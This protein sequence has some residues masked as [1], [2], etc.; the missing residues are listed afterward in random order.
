[1]WK[2]FQ[3]KASD[4]IVVGANDKG[5]QST[6]YGGQGACGVSDAVDKLGGRVRGEMSRRRFFAMSSGALASV[7]AS[8]LFA[9]AAATG[10]GDGFVLRAPLGNPFYGWPE[11]LLSYAVRGEVSAASHT[12][13]CVETGAAVPFQV[14]QHGIAGTAAGGDSILFLSELPV[15]ATRS[16][17]LA[18]GASR[19]VFAHAVTV[20][21]DG[22][23]FTID[24]GAMQVRIPASQVVAGEAPGPI[25]EVARGGGWKGSSRL[26]IPGHRVTRIETEQLETGPLRSAYRITYSIDD[27]A[28]YVATVECCAGMDFVRLHEA[29]EAMPEG[30]MG[31]FHFAWT[32][33][34]FAYRQGPNHPYNFPKQ[35]LAD[36]KQYAWEKMAPTHMDG[37]FGVNPGIGATGKIPYA[38]RLYDPWSD[39]VA[40]SFNNFWGDDSADA[41]MLFIDH[42][43]Q[44]RDHEYA[45]WH[46]SPRLAVEYWYIDR[47]LHFVYKIG[48]GSRSSCI[49]F[50]DHA[51]DVEAMQALTEVARGIVS[52]GLS[53]KTNMFPT[54]HAL[55]TQS[56]HGTLNLD[57]VKDWVLAYPAEKKLPGPVFRESAYRS[58]NA[59]Y[60]AITHNEYVSQ[61]VLSGTRQN[62]G[63]GATG[64]RQILESWVPGYN[65]FRA[66]MS[67]SQRERVEAAMLLMAYVHAGEDYM[68]MKPM[69]AGHPNFLSDVKSTPCGM[70]FL[71]PEHPAADEWADEYEAF[72]RL[73]TRYHTR[74]A[75]AEWRSRGGR[76]T[77]NLGT[78]VWAFLRP[79]SRAAFL[80]KCRD[81]QE[82][83]CGP[84]LAEL[85]DWLVN[86]LSAPFAGESAAWMKRITEESASNESSERHYWGIVKPTGGPRRVHPPIGAHSERRKTPRTM[87]Y[88]GQ[89]LSH[90]SPLTAE[91]VMWAARPTDQD[92]EAT[93]DMGDPYGAMYPAE[94]NLGTNP[95]LKTAK[96]TGYG[97]TLRAAVDTP[98][99]LSIHL[100]QIDDGPNYRWG[101][102]GEGACGVIYF[103]A[104]G[105]GFSH[106][107]FE[108]AGDRIDQDTDF[109]TN[110]GVWKNGV[111]RS[112]GQNV[113]TRPLYDLSVAQYASLVPRQGPEAYSWPEYVGR[114]ILLAGDD[115]FLIY[116]Q[117]FNP[118]INHRF[119][120]FVRKGD[121]FPHIAMLSGR[122]QDA[123]ELF[124]SIET[125]T[126]SGRWVE[127]AGDSVAMITHKDGIRAERAVYGARV[128]HPE[129]TDTVF[130]GP[131]TIEFRDGKRSFT[132][133][134]GLIREREDGFEMALFHG[135]H[136]GAGDVSFTTADTDLGIA[137]KV[138]KS[139]A[140]AG[141]YFAPASSEVAIGLPARDEG[142][143]FYVDGNEVVGERIGNAWKVKLAAG[144]H[145]WELAAGL[146]VPMPP[147]VLR[148]ESLAGG[149]IVY[150]EAVGSAASY[151]L[152]VSADN[153]Q[154]W[155]ENGT[156]AEPKITVSGLTAGK[157]YHVRLIARNAAHA[158]EPGPEYPV[159]ATASA[160]VAPD[161]LNIEIFPDRAEISWGEVLGVTEYRLYRRQIG[162]HDF[163][164]A[165]TGLATHWTDHDVAGAGREYYVRAVNHIGEGRPSRKADSDANS[166]R[167]WVPIPGERF[168]R[169]VERTEGNLPNDGWGRYYP[170]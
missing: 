29:M 52:E 120:W 92:M 82:R 4:A 39:P 42:L 83:L 152:E 79:A 85:G 12:L 163:A 112:I 143:K 128:T 157:K 132:G 60:Q 53:W 41:A 151:A 54:S 103:F 17:R 115:Y 81:G 68:P 25:L 84:Q 113:L 15:G 1:M 55:V 6:L 144:Q 40:E 32:G 137:A 95:H 78:Y 124:T 51:R 57:K 141:T 50:Y 166:W 26:T 116:D 90:Y 64:A 93:V 127:G 94:D 33:C 158:S 133:T 139:G 80:L 135:T 9:E 76:W 70:A 153:A 27:S 99:E 61:L 89:A 119:S 19:A 24:T 72:L 87:W 77:E 71:F 28:K 154:T 150:G 118:E 110:F 58:A 59:L 140:I 66:H 62:S 167:N 122:R 146:P 161:G 126:T 142:L 149:A 74:P 49:G 170:A 34:E 100:L 5:L 160:P 38:L 21:K 156:S 102:A 165:Y 155:T 147:Q 75:V 3:L 129:G 117:V 91:H 20:V 63:F 44:W 45:I 46:S 47:T 65:I 13:R 16:Y 97:V 48:R 145:R 105:K 159:Y 2:C 7:A 111:F 134:A 36:Y 37:Q 108:D 123:T 138:S 121:D 96:Y 164:V 18:A 30:A 69:L 125:N 98:Q 162:G 106:N 131:E 8:G 114:N 104:N 168:R 88:L 101:T 130:V 148:T 31:E 14:T 22:D 23:R 136:L 43:E 11:T 73:N 86:A 169:T 56:W 10:P 35:P 67:A 107:G 109:C